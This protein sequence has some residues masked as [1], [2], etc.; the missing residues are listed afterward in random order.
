M[1]VEFRSA[2]FKLPLCDGSVENQLS[3]GKGKKAWKM[4][5]EIQKMFVML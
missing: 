2:V 4:L 5:F 3:F 1:T